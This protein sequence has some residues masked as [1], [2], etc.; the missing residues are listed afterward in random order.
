MVSYGHD[1]KE[2]WSA[3]K[4][5]G[6]CQEVKLMIYRALYVH[7]LTYGPDVRTMTERTSPGCGRDD[8]HPGSGWGDA[9]CNT[10][11]HGE[12]QV[13]PCIS[14]SR[15]PFS[16][17]SDQCYSNLVYEAEPDTVSWGTPRPSGAERMGRMKALIA[18]L[19]PSTLRDKQ[20]ILKRRWNHNPFFAAHKIT[21][22]FKFSFWT[23]SLPAGGHFY[24]LHKSHVTL[25][26]FY[27]PLGTHYKLRCH[28]L[29]YIKILNLLPAIGSYRENS[30]M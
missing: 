5:T 6:L 9:P 12:A 28:Q 13:E 1:T 17:A 16:D 29:D 19:T 24:F 10:A 18:S 26:C 15:Y 11:M 22:Y 3:M 30:R 2:G 27:T 14:G 20:D 25:F 21:E 7:V 23:P 4:R 8:L